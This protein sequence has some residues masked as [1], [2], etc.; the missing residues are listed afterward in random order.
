MI[1]KQPYLGFKNYLPEKSIRCWTERKITLQIA[2]VNPQPHI[3]EM[4]KQKA[5]LKQARKRLNKK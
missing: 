2:G 4:S 5:N 3:K 1:Q